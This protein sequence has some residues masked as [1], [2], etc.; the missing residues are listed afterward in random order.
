[1]VGKEGQSCLSCFKN[2]KYT[3][4][5]GGR[6]TKGKK[7]LFRVPESL[8][9]QGLDSGQFSRLLWA[10]FPKSYRQWKNTK[11]SNIMIQMNR[12]LAKIY[13]L[14]HKN[15]V[16]DPGL[17]LS[18]YMNS[19]LGSTR[20][21]PSQS[22]AAPMSDQIEIRRRYSRCYGSKIFRWQQTENYLKKRIRIK[23]ENENFLYCVYQ[24]HEAGSWN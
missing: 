16:L 9:C 4:I 12:Y 19:R 23:K 11:M 20:G 7:N 5:H 8:F 3:F 15:M 17:L 2:T 18:L 22:V 21:T 10:M 1:M 13:Q 14:W 24:V 6:N